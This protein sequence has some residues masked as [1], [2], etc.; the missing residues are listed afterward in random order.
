MTGA[1][2]AAAGAVYRPAEV[3][4]PAVEFPPKAPFTSQ[5]TLVVPPVALA[6]LTIPETVALNCCVWPVCKLALV[7]EIETDIAPPGCGMTKTVALA[8][9]AFGWTLCAVTV[10]G[11]DGANAGAVYKP[12]AVMVPT[13]ELPPRIPFASQFTICLLEPDTVAENCCDWPTCRVI[14]GGE[15][16]TA[17]WP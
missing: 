8:D 10:T 3:I 16:T 15:I 17:A 9:G 2:G 7:G 6:V 11:P 12:E 14:E 13:A 4:V 1:D 5:L